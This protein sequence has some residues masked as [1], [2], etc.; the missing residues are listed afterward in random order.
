[1]KFKNAQFV[2][3]ISYC[4]SFEMNRRL[5]DKFCAYS[6]T[7]ARRYIPESCLEDFNSE[8]EFLFAKDVSNGFDGDTNFRVEVSMDADKARPIEEIKK[9]LLD[10]LNSWIKVNL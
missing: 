7:G 6:K 5:Y 8:H 3:T 10:H 4:L 9:I 1:M 2:D